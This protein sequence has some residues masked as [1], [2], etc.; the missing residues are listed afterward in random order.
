[1]A[2][3]DTEG[4]ANIKSLLAKFEA[5]KQENANQAT[6]PKPAAKPR[7]TPKPYGAA[8]PGPKQSVTE[9]TSK[10]KPKPPTPV[11]TTPH[12]DYSSKN[13]PSARSPPASLAFAAPNKT[14]QNG[15][16][17]SLT[18]P[19]RFIKSPT[20]TNGFIPPKF[21]PLE[22]KGRQQSLKH[23]QNKRNSA[24]RYDA[25]N[26]HSEVKVVPEKI[27]T[28]NGSKN[29]NNASDDRTE[30]FVELKI[31][32]LEDDD[33]P[34]RPPLPKAYKLP[35]YDELALQL[36]EHPLFSTFGVQTRAAT[37]TAGN[38]NTRP[39]SEDDY[40]D[41][42]GALAAVRNLPSRP[43]AS[44]PGRRSEITSLIPE[45]TEE[46]ELEQDDDDEEDFYQPIGAPLGEDPD[47]PNPDYDDIN[48][49]RRSELLR[50]SQLENGADR[51]LEPE[52]TYESI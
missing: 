35:K 37:T 47:D 25:E 7:L 19:K 12:Q 34:N 40:D 28:S 39:I 51:D 33:P 32:P 46:E 9:E 4:P 11:R 29:E 10:P 3:A 24:A 17:T 8:A 15:D 2:A 20:S 48:D 52:D 42:E 16:D 44:I 30:K 5:A 1:M 49:L 13:S 14:T 26:T 27:D 36:L 45:F 50:N 41:L 23:V 18:S 31:P 43:R 6:K 38:G 22:I 21:N